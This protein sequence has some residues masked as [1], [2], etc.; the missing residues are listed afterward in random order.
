MYWCIYSKFLK[1]YKNKYIK[2]NTW[3]AIGEAFGLDAPEV[4]KRYKSIGTSY[5]R[6]W[7]KRKSVPS[8]SGR[9]A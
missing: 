2:F 5:G 8:V 6:Y 3:K 4:E 9:D 1:D 7:N